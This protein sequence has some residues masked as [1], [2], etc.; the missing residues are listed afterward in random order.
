MDKEAV[1][2][3][4]AQAAIVARLEEK[5]GVKFVPAIT[6]KEVGRLGLSFPEFGQDV[7]IP[8]YNRGG[9]IREV[10]AEGKIVKLEPG[11]FVVKFG[12]YPIIGTVNQIRDVWL[13][14]Y[15]LSRALEED[16]RL[17]EVEG[18]LR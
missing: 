14:T 9:V 13:Y 18:E 17:T 4:E 16:E 12:E 8:Y 15:A 11:Q 2:D 1:A 7:E 10:G 6:T 3:I 5:F